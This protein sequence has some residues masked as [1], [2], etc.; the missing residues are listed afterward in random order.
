[1]S[2]K[3]CFLV[4]AV[5][6][7]IF[8]SAQCIWAADGFWSAQA[9]NPGD[10]SD[11]NNWQ[12]G[13][14]ADGDGSSAWFYVDAPTS[15]VIT[16]NVDALRAGQLIGNLYFIDADPSTPGSYLIQG[17]TT[18]NLQNTALG[19]S[20]ISP[21]PVFSG[22]VEIVAAEISAPMS[23]ADG[24]SLSIVGSGEIGRAHV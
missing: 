6:V 8:T 2:N 22:G 19:V 10:W 21:S 13:T 3:R 1:M 14:V 7:V 16:V 17:T 15:P 12:S 23:V 20:T 11:T 9:A 5:A 4:A 24:T 18:L